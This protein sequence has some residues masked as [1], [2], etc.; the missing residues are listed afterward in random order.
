MATLQRLDIKVHQ[1]EVI[2]DLS[3]EIKNTQKILLEDL[4]KD[5][6]KEEI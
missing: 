4:E 3:E 5:L 6:F 1:E 2:K